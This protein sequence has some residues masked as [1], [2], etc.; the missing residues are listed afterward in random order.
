MDGSMRLGDALAGG[1]SRLQS[2]HIIGHYADG[3]FRTTEPL[4]ARTRH[5]EY[6]GHLQSRGGRARA[7]LQILLRGT[8]PVPEPIRIE[9]RGNGA[10]DFSVAEIMRT[11][12]PDFMREFTRIQDRF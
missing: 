7:Q 4:T 3:V 12:D 5:T 11:F 10:R 8:A 2:L 1:T 6:S 9:V